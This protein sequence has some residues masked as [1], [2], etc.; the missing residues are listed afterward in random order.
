MKYRV[1]YM[2]RVLTAIDQQV[3][4]LLEQGVSTDRVTGWIESLF[5]LTDSLEQWPRRNPVAEDATARV[6]TEI[7][8]IRFG[9]YLIFYQV[10]DANRCVNVMHFR[11]AAQETNQI[12]D[13]LEE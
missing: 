4:Y 6:G 9:D 3:K 10:D 1:Q 8:K 7:R 12:T 11:H 5:D 13:L 2:P